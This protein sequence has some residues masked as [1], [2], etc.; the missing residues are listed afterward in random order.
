[1]TLVDAYLVVDW[2]ARS[3]PSPTRP[4]R[5]AV[6]VGERGP[7]GSCE[8]YCRT[9]AAATAHVRLRLRDLVARGLRVLVGF[10]VPYGYPA[11][12]AACLGLDGQAPWRAVWD[13]LAERIADTAA[14]ENNRF[15]VAAELNREVGGGPGPFWGCPPSRASPS[16]P[17]G[18]SGLFTFPFPARAAILERLRLTEKRMPGVQEAWKLSGAGSVGSQALLGIPRVR[19]LRDDPVLVPVSAVWPFETGFAPG[20]VPDRGPFVLHVE[21]WPGIVEA[22]T[23]AAEMERT[24]AIP[25]QAQVRLMCEWA[26]AQDRDGALGA[27]LDATSL[28]DGERRA[29]V[30]EEGWILGCPAQGGGEGRLRRI[31]VRFPRHGTPCSP[32]AAIH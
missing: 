2:S 1:M 25:D 23:V 29:A 18:R 7:D 16:L 13:L 4:A 32:P 5:D 3:R 26:H 11:G 8:T 19:D 12:F 27:W 22:A 17:S 20:P 14:N 28:S 31:R 24:R 6:W 9:R 10:D 15:A 21:I 30:E